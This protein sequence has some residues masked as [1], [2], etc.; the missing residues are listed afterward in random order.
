MRIM[1]TF[2]YYIV[3]RL[4]EINGLERGIMQNYLQPLG[5]KMQRYYCIYIAYIVYNAG[6][7]IRFLNATEG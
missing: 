2:L 4:Y 7:L 1:A 5:L 3:C 6:Q